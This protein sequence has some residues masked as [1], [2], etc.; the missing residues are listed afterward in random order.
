M[1]T[2][3][4]PATASDLRVVAEVLA[5]VRAGGDSG[6]LTLKHAPPPPRY[7]TSSWRPAGVA[8]EW[9]AAAGT[10]GDAVALYVHGRRFR[11]DEPAGALAARFSGAVGIPV[12][13]LHHR[14]AP[15]DPYPAA[16]EDVLAAYRTLLALRP[17]ERIVLAGH[18]AGAT[19]VLSA[20]AELA[21]GSEPMPAAVV[22]VSPIAD[23]TLS[24]ATLSANADKDVVALAELEAARDAYLGAADPAGAPQSPLFAPLAGLPPLLLCCG[25][26]EMLLDDT[27]RVAERADAAGVD[28]TVE[29][30]ERMVHGF[31]VLPVTAADALLRRISEFCGEWLRGGP[32]PRAP[33]PLSIRRVGWAGYE[34]T[35]ELGT[36]VVVDPYLTDSEGLHLGLPESPVAPGELC[37]AD[38]VAVTHAGYDHRGQAIEIVEG[39]EA[40]L[41]CGAALHEHALRHGIAPGRC[42]PM[43]SGVEFRYRD[44]AVKALDARH[45][46]SMRTGGE[47]VS[48]QPL[49][50][51]VSTAAGSRIFCGGDVSL[52]ADMRTWRELYRPQVAVLGIGGV[53]PGTHR[54]VEL[55]PAEAAIAAAWLGVHTVIPV[56]HPPG[57]P[58]PAQLEADIAAAGAPVRV[59]ALELGEA[60]TAGV[61]A[62]QELTGRTSRVAGRRGRSPARWARRGRG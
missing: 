35:S 23:F 62:S 11:F 6:E 55:P 8:A 4:H 27:L 51:L 57:D 58:A 32:A 7:A 18:S 46:S 43:V 49:S 54:A 28:V 3:H 14:L 36:R 31:P 56:H 2:L 26:D 12:L 33:R 42:A 53:G 10:R 17:A 9:V 1:R 44:V 60:W 25:G 52:S 13:L 24:G 34:I 47:L 22:A 16:L 29:R 48:D 15:A 37:G 30:F 38:I 40:T 41:V 59:A 19:L 39:G 21:A 20:L 61:T 45:L 50:F 5:D